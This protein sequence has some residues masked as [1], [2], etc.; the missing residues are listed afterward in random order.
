M[1]VLRWHPFGRGFQATIKRPYHD[2]EVLPLGVDRWQWRASRMDSANGRFELV[3][4]GVEESVESARAAA[5]DAV[6]RNV[7][8]FALIRRA[9]Q[10][11]WLETSQLNQALQRNK[12]KSLGAMSHRD[13]YHC[14]DWLE[15]NR[16][17]ESVRAIIREPK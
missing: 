11:H 3:E 8:W 14:L 10:T 16:G 7:D 5:F 2:L 1:S 4:A 6:I 17:L 13:A 12:S 15:N 9:L